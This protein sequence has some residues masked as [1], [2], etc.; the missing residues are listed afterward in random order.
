[1]D[2][3]KLLKNAIR[4]GILLG[5]CFLASMAWANSEA[6]DESQSDSEE[7]IEIDPELEGTLYGAILKVD[8]KAALDLVAEGWDVDIRNSRD[9]TYLL[10]FLRELTPKKNLERT[11]LLIKCGADVNA[12]D[13]HGQTP[14]YLAMSHHYYE[15]IQ[16]LLEN[17]ADPHDFRL[18]TFIINYQLPKGFKIAQ[19]ELDLLLKYGADINEPDPHG[20]TPLHRTMN[21]I[22]L[23]D[24][25]QLFLDHGA[26]INA[27]NHKGETPLD[28]A[29]KNRAKIADDLDFKDHPDWIESFQNEY[30]RAIAFLREHGAVE[31]QSHEEHEAESKAEDGDS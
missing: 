23:F 16:I 10:L 27:T 7:I 3:W 26:A 17:G 14:L 8:E 12:K 2:R 19:A 24:L 11:K 31:S 20:N 1:M 9:V 29:I 28:T 6:K 5:S 4:N 15:I 22:P 21:G 13:I 18:F 30:D 25:A